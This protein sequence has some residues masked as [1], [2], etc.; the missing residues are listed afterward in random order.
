MGR[1]WKIAIGVL[2]ALAVL[3]GVNALV[4]DGRTARR[5]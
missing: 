5:R 2:V 3:L 4:V 1:G